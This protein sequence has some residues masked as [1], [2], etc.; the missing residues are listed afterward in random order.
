MQK[1]VIIPK[2]KGYQE[3]GSTLTTSL[4]LNSNSIKQL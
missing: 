3:G 1:P 2:F 4:A